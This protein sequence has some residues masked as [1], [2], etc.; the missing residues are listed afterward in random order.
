LLSAGQP[1]DADRI[2]MQARLE[3]QLRDHV[4]TLLTP[5]LG[6][7][8][9]SSEIQLDL[10]M[11]QQ[12]SARESYDKQGAVRSET[13]TATQSGSGAAAGGAVGV[14]G[15]LSNTP[16]PA[17]TA[18]PGPPTANTT[19]A[20]TPSSA[21]S[22]T[23]G[24]ADTSSTRTYELGREV[25]VTNAGPGKI[26]R[27]SVAVALSAAAMAKAK[28]G[29]IDQIKQLVSAA[30]GA[31]PARGD[32]IAVV[33]RAFQPVAIEQPKFWETPWFAMAVRNGVALLAVLM[34][35][36]LGV[37]PLI[38]ALKRE[39]GDS[40]EVR[41][42]PGPSGSS[43]TTEGAPRQ[44]LPSPA[45]QQ[46]IDPQMLGKQVNLAQQMVREQ[47]D[48]AVAALRQMLKDPEAEPA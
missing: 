46:S 4:E 9:F 36:L 2:E 18:S 47:P 48:T 21:P 44:A 1:G 14:P 6:A 29:E 27:L 23:P 38:K 32:Q 16:P 17:A 25:A 35:L 33:V 11:D 22:A 5:I 39:P 40:A 20:A 31:D 37:R 43:D 41:A 13:Q 12:T 34:T 42:L 15:I 28:P 30:V 45:N 7:G 3:S 26:R 24:N 10:D 8:N 19:P